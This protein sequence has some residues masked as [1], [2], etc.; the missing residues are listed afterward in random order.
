NKCLSGGQCQVNSSNSFG[1]SCACPCRFFGSRCEKHKVFKSCKELSKCEHQDGEHYL[2]LQ[3]LTCRK[4]VLVY[5]ADMNTTEPKEY[6]TLNSGEENNFSH[7][8]NTMSPQEFNHYGST[9]KFS[10]IRIT[11]DLQIT[12][13]DHRFAR[14]TWSDTM[15]I[16]QRYGSAGDCVTSDCTANKIGNFRMDIRDTGLYFVT[17]IKWS[18]FGWPSEC[19]EHQPV[20]YNVDV[21][22]QV[23]SGKCGA[24]NSDTFKCRT[25][26]HRL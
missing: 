7:L 13:T 24:R 2:Q 9:T 4:S 14:L 10:K 19:A 15:T 18:Y 25:E 23:V 5:C 26:R 6:I 17:P 16:F 12:T 3:F 20:N 22:K 8:D 11:A 1:F 21:D